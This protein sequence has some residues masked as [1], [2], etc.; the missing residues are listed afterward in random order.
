MGLT[1]E[2]VSICVS[3][4]RPVERMR[5]FL[6][7]SVDVVVFLRFICSFFLFHSPFRHHLFKMIEKK[8]N[9]LVHVVICY[10]V[11]DEK[12]T[13][14]TIFTNKMEMREHLKTIER[15]QL[16]ARYCQRKMKYSADK[17]IKSFVFLCSL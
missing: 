6:S 1:N 15:E 14:T 11:L 2:P 4:S 17:R 10:F 12:K 5:F 7:H 9:E 8:N 3:S 13:H 16:K